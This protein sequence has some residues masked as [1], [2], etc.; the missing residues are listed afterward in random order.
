MI[1]FLKLNIVLDIVSDPQ[2]TRLGNTEKRV[3]FILI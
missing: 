1:Y 2:M 3:I